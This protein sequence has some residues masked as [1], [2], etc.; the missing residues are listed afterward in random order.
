MTE[1]AQWA[2]LVKIIKQ[3][4]GSY[5]VY[6]LLIKW[7]SIGSLFSHCWVFI[8]IGSSALHTLYTLHTLNKLH[9]LKATVTNPKGSVE[10]LS[11]KESPEDAHTALRICHSCLDCQ[12][13]EA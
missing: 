5:W 11:P 1:T 12:I 3:N 13:H 9:T 7:V 2:D 4:S 8:L 10:K 6:I